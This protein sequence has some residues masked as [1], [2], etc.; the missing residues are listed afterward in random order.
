[1]AGDAVSVF[2]SSFYCDWVLYIMIEVELLVGEGGDVMEMLEGE[3][4]G[5]SL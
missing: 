4:G 1:M 3:A 5:Q 2:R